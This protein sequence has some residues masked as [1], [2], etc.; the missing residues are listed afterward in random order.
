VYGN[1]GGGSMNFVVARDDADA[2]TLRTNSAYASYKWM[3]QLRG[4]ACYYA[5]FENTDQWPMGPVT[6]DWFTTVGD[7]CGD[8]A[9]SPD[10]YYLAFDMGHFLDDPVS[11]QRYQGRIIPGL[12]Q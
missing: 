8:F 2:Q 7:D 6:A 10:C 1:H 3:P 5:A 12:T 4:G 11:G 9:M